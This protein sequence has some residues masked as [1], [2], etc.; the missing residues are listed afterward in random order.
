[1]SNLIGSPFED[2]VKKQIETRQKAL[3][4]TQNISADNLKYYTTKTPW[5]R[6]ASSVDL[7]GL[8]DDGGVLD[9]LIKAGVPRD[10]IEGDNLAKNF[11]LQGG[12]VS[13][14]ETTNDK[15]EVISS[16]AKLQKGL[17]YNNE[18]F[19]GAYGW[20]G[21]T[22]RGFIPMPGIEGASTN[23]YNNGALSQS[24]IR[25]KCYSKAQFQLLDALYLRPGYTLLLE[26][27][28]STFL[29]NSGE[30]Q[31]YEG[32]KSE[33]LNFLL[34]PNSFD[35]GQNQFQMLDLI[36]Q[37]RRKY[38]GNY[39]AV[40]GKITNFKWSFSTD[41]SY[42]CEVKLIGM[43]SVIESLK[44]N[45]TD[46]NKNN[47][48]NKTNNT[49]GSDLD[50]KKFAGSFFN[51]QIAAAIWQGRDV[52]D[53]NLT[54]QAVIMTKSDRKLN[55]GSSAESVKSFL[56]TK[57]DAYITAQE[58]IEN[59]N[60]NNNPLLAN[61]DDT[62]L[63]KIFYDAYQFSTGKYEGAAG[64]MH[65]I[66]N[67]ILNGS[68]ILSDTFNGDKS[69]RKGGGD[70][71]DKSVYLKFA[72]LLKILEENCNL[73]SMKDGG[74]PMIKFDFS[75]ANM[76]NDDNYMLIIPPN[77]STDPQKCLVPYT[78]MTI[79][80]VTS[81][82]N[83]IPTDT[84]LN[85]EL[86][87]NSDFFVDG[88][89][90][91]GRLGNVLINLK[92]AA[93]ALATA[94]RDDS[95]AISVLEYLKT[96]LQGISDSMGGINNFFTSYDENNGL[97]RIYD[98]TPKPGLIEDN[99]SRYTK[100]NIFGVKENQGSFVTN[101]GLDAEIPKNFAAMIAIGSQTSGNNLMGNSTSFSSYN[102][103]LI[104]RI[105]PQ[106]IDSYTKEA[107]DDEADPTKQAKTIKQE[108][109][110]YTKDSKKISPLAAIYLKGGQAE[111]TNKNVYN[112][113]S[114][115]TNDL[116]ENYQTY[117]QLV[118]G[119][120]SNA[121][122]VPAPFFLP[123]NL[124]LELEGISGI[125][126][127]EKF[128]IS[129]D[130]LPPSYE[131]GSVDII[132]KALN[133]DVSIQTWKTAIDTQSVPA[134]KP[135]KIESK[136]TTTNPPSE[137]QQKLEAAAETPT[138]TDPNEDQ[139]VRLRLTRLVDNGFQTL[140]IMEVLDENGKTLYG[141]PTVELPWKDNQT[142]E[143]CI[144]TGTYTVASRMSPSYGDC[145]II[146]NESD[147][148][149]A[150]LADGGPIT[151]YNKKNRQWVLIHEAPAAK[152]NSG[153]NWLEGCMAPGFKFNTKQSDKFGNPRGIGFPYGNKSSGA[154][155]E[156][157]EANKKLL[158]TLWNV[159]KNPMFKL[160]IKALGGVN[161][162]IEKNFYSFSVDA[163]VR[164]IETK[165]GER[166]TYA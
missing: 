20:G 122:Q 166:Y 133:H 100:L 60:I 4:Q 126:L 108:K 70:K 102:Q 67:G 128:K 97:I 160:K 75:Y 65:V 110:Y 78:K 39:E 1:M 9:K 111:G 5:L 144:P 18:M 46:P 76:K 88:N 40:Y 49:G 7:M 68:F 8:P 81:Y 119:V 107:K 143:S 140:G 10:I 154:H 125:K 12:T 64:G 48:S 14:E 33:P 105:I 106:K 62:K 129:D 124:N 161:K 45:V 148:R 136:E 25:I 24:T 164:K 11:I 72:T 139:I 79:D 163:E 43:G 135:E 71:V 58:T 23:Y 61:K 35:G 131:K 89:P 41:G 96:V 26:F 2:Y 53:F 83:D 130:I 153:K 117:I 38:N 93:E 84:P 151:G 32:F 115:I 6:L 69:T 87:A 123:F 37:E 19:N 77:I 54:N 156:S 145:F 15:N 29:D 132:V 127:F 50:F 56:R 13:L 59:E 120:L 155:L 104:D 3:G 57:Y 98:E 141:L 147:N 36:Q 165:T 44:L 109:L 99:P 113:S 34:K 142:G 82:G 74:T 146:A 66:S 31:T 27:G 152:P 90:Y 85:K 30:L 21:I 52:R 17:N 63:N 149:P 80:G 114:E 42:S 73:F 16:N 101:I 118:Q 103:G 92:F 116:T 134:F 28:W 159:G 121:N 51:Q 86:T 150:I 95:G 55:F 137:K 157:I 138:A 158:G 91:V 94:S 22:E 112:F 47:Q 162:P